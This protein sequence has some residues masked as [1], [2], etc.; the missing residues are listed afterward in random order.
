LDV[1]EAATLPPSTD[2]E[3]ARIAATAA[4]EEDR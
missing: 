2:E 4:G 1:A 3:L